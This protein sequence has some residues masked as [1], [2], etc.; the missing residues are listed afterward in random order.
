MLLCGPAARPASVGP[1][2]VLLPE[3]TWRRGS[4][5][6]V[7]PGC[8]LVPAWG[9]PSPG[10]PTWAGATV[11]FVPPRWRALAALRAA[12]RFV[13]AGRQVLARRPGPAGHRVAARRRAT[14][15]Q[16]IAPRRSPTVGQHIAARRGPKV[17]RGLTSRRSPTIRQHIAARRGPTVGRLFGPGT[18]STAA[19]RALIP[20]QRL[21]RAPLVHAAP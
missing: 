6:V 10:G 9:G 7:R 19:P 18:P 15:E 12:P 8:R 11:G 17:G 13:L 16:D 14:I 2:F 3:A 20:G 4:A 5:G 21:G 1:G